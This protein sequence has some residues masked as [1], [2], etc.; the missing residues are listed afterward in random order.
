MKNKGFLILGI[1]LFL[2][3]AGQSQTYEEYLKQF[4]SDFKKFREQQDQM[5]TGLRQD[6][7]DYVRKRDKEYSDYLKTEWENF[8]VFS[9]NI[10]PE[11]PKPKTIP[12]FR[13]TSAPSVVRLPVITPFP[14][15]TPELPAIVK[16]PVIQ[17]PESREFDEDAFFITFYGAKVYLDIDRALRNYPAIQSG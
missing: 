1:S 9:G 16:V 12:E 10:P 8:R 13:R 6:Y 3:S 17:K 5:I 2:L 14:A 11:K 15:T 7:S 4:Q